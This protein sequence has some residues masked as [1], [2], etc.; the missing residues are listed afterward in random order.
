MTSELNLET[1]FP[2]ILYYAL[3]EVKEKAIQWPVNSKYVASTF[4]SKSIFVYSSNSTVLYWLIKATSYKFFFFTSLFLADWWFLTRRWPSGHLTPFGRPRPSLLRRLTLL[5]GNTVFLK[6][7]GKN[8]WNTIRIVKCNLFEVK[9]LI[10]ILNLNIPLEQKVI[11]LIQTW[12]KQLITQ[13]RLRLETSESVTI[14]S[15][16]LQ[17][18]SIP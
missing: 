1:K 11:T 7:T 4:L 5:T 18:F 15:W 17:K 2:P 3:N 10:S 8:G 6:Q 14:L 16:V 12:S 9:V 13:K